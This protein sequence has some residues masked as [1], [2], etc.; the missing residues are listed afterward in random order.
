MVICITL[1]DDKLLAQEALAGLDVIDLALILCFLQSGFAVECLARHTHTHLAGQDHKE[2][3]HLMYMCV[4][5]PKDSNGVVSLS[6]AQAQLLLS[7]FPKR[8]H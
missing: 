2:Q 7:G 1:C 5:S 3:T 8:L 6:Q 4:S